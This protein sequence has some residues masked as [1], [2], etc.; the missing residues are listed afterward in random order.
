MFVSFATN[1]ANAD[2]GNEDFFAATGN[3]AVLLDADASPMGVE[4]SCSHGA[5]W[6]ARQLGIRCLESAADI[7]ET[8]T[9]VL[10]SAIQHVAALHRHSCDLTSE[11]APSSSV[12]I[13]REREDRLEYLVL[14]DSA[15]VARGHSGTQAISDNREAMFAEQY[16]PLLA[17]V[18]RT[19]RTHDVAVKT[20]VQMMS[21]H[22]N[23]QGGFWVAGADPDVA[24]HALTGVLYPE[25]AQ[26]VALLSDGASRPV[27]RFD[28]LSWDYAIE[29]LAA[30]GPK[31]WLRRVRRAEEED[32]H[33]QR[34]PR[35]NLHDDA[36]AAILLPEW[37]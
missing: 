21:E 24:R 18:G 28:L 23:Q 4:S 9:G 33:G 3:I 34:W 20:Y 2:R 11:G 22:R 10:Q 30:G 37:A 13:L 29:E 19:G 7:S 8:L 6:F 32:P 17:V 15:L 35:T 5:V 14:A 1:P 36:T 26:I 16:Q 27:D 25:D 31:Q 12:I